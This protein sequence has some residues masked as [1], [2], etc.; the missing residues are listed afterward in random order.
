MTT[1]FTAVIFG[2]FNQHLA[3]VASGYFFI[4][5]NNF[6]VVLFFFFLNPFFNKCSFA[7][8]VGTF[9]NH[10]NFPKIVLIA[11]AFQSLSLIL[12]FIDKF[13][14][15]LFHSFFVLFLCLF[16]SFFHYRCIK[17][18]SID[19]FPFCFFHS[20]IVLFIC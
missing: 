17:T 3:T 14:F 6:A 19:H 15:C 18:W 16:F 1:L 9:I 7:K 11:M 8:F 4:F 2:S 20:F 12:I 5:H 13:L 10:S